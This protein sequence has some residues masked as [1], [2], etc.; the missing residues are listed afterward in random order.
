MLVQFSQ[1]SSL[2]ERNENTVC[3][4]FEYCDGNATTEMLDVRD[5]SVLFLRI[6]A[7][8]N[9]KIRTLGSQKLTISGH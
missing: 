3:F 9:K 7:K 5:E 4:F 6:Q 8:V 1:W 2:E